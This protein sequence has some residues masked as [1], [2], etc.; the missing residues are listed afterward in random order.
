M[1]SKRTTFEGREVIGTEVVV[2]GAT[3]DPGGH[4][5]YQVGDVVFLVCEAV[6]QKVTHKSVKDSDKLIRV[7]AA[8]SLIGAVVDVD[9]VRGAIELAR[10]NAEAKSGIQRLDLD[11]D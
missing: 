8:R 5:P 7:A 9:L 11:G 3:A 4:D 6:V 1:A 10:M 2:S